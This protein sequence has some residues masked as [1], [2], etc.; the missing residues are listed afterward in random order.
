MADTG[1][2]T[3]INAHADTYT[4]F[5]TLMYRGTALAVFLAALVVFLI[6]S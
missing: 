2:V 4:G 1:D 6:A 5:T 3:D